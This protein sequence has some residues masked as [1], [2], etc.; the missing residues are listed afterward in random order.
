MGVS[1]ISLKK[2]KC[3]KHFSPIDRSAGSRSNNLANRPGCSGYVALQYSSRTAYTFSRS[4][5]TWTVDL[6]PFASGLYRT[7]ARRH[8][9]SVLSILISFILATSSVRTRSKIPMTPAEW[10]EFRFTTSP[11]ARTI[12]SLTSMDRW[13][14]P[15]MSS[16]F[17]PALRRTTWSSIGN[18]VKCGMCLAHSTNWYNCRSA[19][20]HMFW[21][22]SCS[23]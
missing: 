21:T 12:P 9:S 23:N 6:R 3:S 20:W 1:P 4:A 15:A 7:M 13:L 22:G 19:A 5:S 17:H 14:N 2:N 8:P 11:V 18:S 10:A 16:S